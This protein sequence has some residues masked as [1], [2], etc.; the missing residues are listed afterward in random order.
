MNYC[1]LS[2]I[3]MLVV[4]VVTLTPR[5]NVLQLLETFEN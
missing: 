4:D 2:Q 5:G 3:W 1:L